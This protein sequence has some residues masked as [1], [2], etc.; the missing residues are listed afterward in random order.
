[1]GIKKRLAAY[2]ALF[3]LLSYDISSLSFEREGRAVELILA[4]RLNKLRS[5]AVLAGTP[6]LTFSIELSGLIPASFFD[7]GCLQLT[8]AGT[9]RFGTACRRK[10]I[11]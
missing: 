2:K 7:L 11:R 9:G 6:L 1:M 4:I 10:K 8:P 5:S 3:L